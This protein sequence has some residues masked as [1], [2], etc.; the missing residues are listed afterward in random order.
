MADPMQTFLRC[1]IILKGEASKNCLKIGPKLEDNLSDSYMCTPMSFC[2]FTDKFS[3]EN[4]KI[5]NL[6]KTP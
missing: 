3:A 2:L 1:K 6:D 5:I 4:L